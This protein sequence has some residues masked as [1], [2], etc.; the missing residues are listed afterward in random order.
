MRGAVGACKMIEPAQ[1]KA[2]AAKLWAL[3]EQAV[4]LSWSV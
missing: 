4:D 1:D 2:A 3:S